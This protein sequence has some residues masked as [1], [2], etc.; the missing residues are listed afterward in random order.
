MVLW[1]GRSRRGT[2]ATEL[3]WKTVVTKTFCSDRR[4][5]RSYAL[6]CAVSALVANQSLASALV[7]KNVVDP[8]AAS[9]FI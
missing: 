9:A 2:G 3:G 8:D 4:N 6:H 7:V 5:W 1:A